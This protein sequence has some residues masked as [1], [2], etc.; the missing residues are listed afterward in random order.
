M[1]NEIVYRS[2]LAYSK[3][4][5]DSFDFGDLTATMAG[6]KALRARQTVTTTPE[7]LVLGEVAAAS[8]WLVL[9]NMD[10]TNKVL[11]R[12]ATGAAVCIEVQPGETSGPFRFASTWTA[13][14][15]E[16]SAATVDFIYFLVQA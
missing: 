14:F 8:A 5:A 12:P 13:P 2:K 11:V 7:A 9:K 1:A 10:A 4:D 6:S 3:G 15:V 16:A